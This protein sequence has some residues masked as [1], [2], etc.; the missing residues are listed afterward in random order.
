MLG[1]PPFLVRMR[2]F[3]SYFVD[4]PYIGSPLP[5]DMCILPRDRHSIAVWYESHR[6][7]LGREA[8]GHLGAIS[9]STVTV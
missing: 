6:I 8:C 9:V 5:Q 3:D 4:E 2:G 1:E 7:I